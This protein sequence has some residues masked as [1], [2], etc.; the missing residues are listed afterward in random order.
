MRR[1]A[2]Y[3]KGDKNDGIKRKYDEIKHNE[4]PNDKNK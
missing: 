4:S 2:Y 1:T 3:Y